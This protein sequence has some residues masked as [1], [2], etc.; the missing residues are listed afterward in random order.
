MAIDSSIIP[1]KATANSLEDN[2]TTE[3]TPGGKIQV[4]DRV[5]NQIADNSVGVVLA[6]STAGFTP[7]AA[8]ADFF[9]DSNG[10]E[11]SISTG[12]TDAYFN[13]SGSDYEIGAAKTPWLHYLL[14]ET[15][16]TNVDNTGSSATD[17]TAAGVTSWVSGKLNNALQLNALGHITSGITSYPSATTFIL[18]MWV[19]FT[20]H[21]VYQT[22]YYKRTSSDGV[23]INYNNSPSQLEFWLNA[24]GSQLNHSWTPTDDVW[25]HLIFWYDKATG[26]QR[27]YIDGAQVAE[28]NYST[29]I[30]SNSQQA[31][32][33]SSSTDGT[34]RFNGVLDDVRIYTTALSQQD[35]DFLYNSGNGTEDDIAYTSGRIVT[36]AL[37]TL[38]GSNQNIRLHAYHS[39]IPTGT[40]ITYDVDYTGDGTYEKTGLALD[41]WESLGG[42]QTFTNAKIRIVLDMGTGSST[43]LLQGY[44]V[45][46]DS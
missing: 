12:D 34:D 19:K 41:T 37:P 8:K 2:I 29:D 25:Y 4:A 38:D 22:L 14:N 15:S 24:T 39:T 20:A 30:G 11:N 35:I 17:G 5:Q 42:A 21:T 33:G 43:P 16:G 40:S 23:I 7:T 32:F 46:V 9:S 28:T 6:T 18:A 36:V 26:K 3:A 1:S 10:K 44:C 31:L 27:I 45:M 13:A